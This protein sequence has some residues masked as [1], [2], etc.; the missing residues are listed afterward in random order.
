MNAGERAARLADRLPVADERWREAM[1][2]VPRHLFIPD[3]AWCL[4]GDG[5]PGYP[6]D[7]GGEPERWLDAVYS[8]AAIITQ[9]D[10]GATDVAEGGGDYTSSS[11]MPEIVAAELELLDPYDGDEVLEIGTGTGWTAALLAHRLGPDSVTSVEIDPAV[12][13]AAAG[14]LKRAGY[15]PRVVLGDGADGWP[16]GGPYDRVHVTC[17]ATR[18]PYAWI[19]QTRPGGMIV[20][21]WMSGWGGHL[22]RL[23]VTADGAAGGGF[24]QACGFMLLRSQRAAPGGIE[25]DYRDSGTLLDP[26]RI[27]RAGHGAE[28]AL[29]GLLPDVS[30]VH[31]EEDDGRFRLWVT[32]A[33]SEAQ[34][35]HAP[36]YRQAAVHQRGPRDLWDEVEAAF[37][38]WVSWGSPGRDRF[39]LT[40]TAEE[41]YVWLDRPGS[42]L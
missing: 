42:R 18:V 13:E 12:H 30:R 28:V 14:N 19:A 37:M 33:G 4:P 39:G 21:P 25:G 6:I 15:A 26:R 23:T 10:D 9:V 27:A 31:R 5:S 17:G 41:Q 3:Q 38:R 16:E 20:F 11:S 36:G 40:V 7:R 24:H 32:S 34:V 2:A 22:T 35:H 8:A 29:A 1:R